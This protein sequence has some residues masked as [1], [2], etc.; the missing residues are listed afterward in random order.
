MALRFSSSAS[1]F[2][3]YLVAAPGRAGDGLI[4]DMC[5]TLSYKNEN[6][7]TW[8]VLNVGNGK[9]FEGK[10]RDDRYINHVCRPDFNTFQV[11]LN[12]FLFILPLH[13]RRLK[14]L[15]CFFVCLLLLA[16]AQIAFLVILVEATLP[17]KL[18]NG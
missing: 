1:S 8:R 12:D 18:L 14:C 5:I 16:L 4:I 9:T 15:L 2:S 10:E 17:K 3:S 13:V 7:Y 11:K 6:G